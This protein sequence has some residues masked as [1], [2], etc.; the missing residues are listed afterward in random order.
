MP[1][2]DSLQGP[3]GPKGDTGVPGF[4]G[5]KGEQVGAQVGMCLDLAGHSYLANCF[6]LETQSLQCNSLTFKG[7]PIITILSYLDAFF[8]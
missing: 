1:S 5:L 2:N 7:F 4:P 6:L 3:R 8:N